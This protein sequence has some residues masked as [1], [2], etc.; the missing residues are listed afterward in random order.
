[1]FKVAWRMGAL[2]LAVG[3]TLA[4][5]MLWQHGWYVAAIWP[6]LILLELFWPD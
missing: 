6:L 2:A 4:A 1:M 3:A 5:V